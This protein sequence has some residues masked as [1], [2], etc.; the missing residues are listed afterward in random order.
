M[1]REAAADHLS[2]V[3]AFC[4]NLTW[5]PPSRERSRLA[6][7]QLPW[8]RRVETNPGDVHWN[9]ARIWSGHHLQNDLCLSRLRSAPR[10]CT[11]QVAKLSKILCKSRPNF[12]N[13]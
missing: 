5:L 1:E 6:T 3:R 4:Y 12:D 8:R 2:V 10:L 13:T 11:C 7:F 9:E